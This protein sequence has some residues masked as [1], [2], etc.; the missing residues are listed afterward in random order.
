MG[1][2]ARFAVFL[3]ALALLIVVAS[4]QLSAVSAS[5]FSSNVNSTGSEVV[6]DGFIVQGTSATPTPTASGTPTPTPTASGTPTPTATPNPSPSATPTSTTTSVPTATPTST[7]SSTPSATPTGTPPASTTPTAT[8]TQ[9]AQLQ[10]E[11]RVAL[12]RPAGAAPSS[13]EVPLTLWVFGAGGWNAERRGALLT[14]SATTS[15]DGVAV[16]GL[17]GLVPGSYDLQ[18]KGAHTLSRLEAERSLA[19]GV[20]VVEFG[21]LAEGD[22]NGD[23]EV[24]GADYQYSAD[25]FGLRSGEGSFDLAADLTTDGLVDVSD[26]SL[27][28]GNHGTKGPVR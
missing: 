21:T 23:D 3:V 19:A 20:N 14:L 4:L 11:A 2:V 27:L 22:T 26:L 7:A 17:P 5:Q 28:A 18:V 24:S 9:T 25:R 12:Q 15:P 10:V 6:I 8:A 1:S 16:F 13:R